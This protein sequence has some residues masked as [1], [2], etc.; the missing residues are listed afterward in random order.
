MCQAWQ[1]S[2]PNIHSRLR[3]LGLIPMPDP[4]LG[5]ARPRRRGLATIWKQQKTPLHVVLFLLKSK[6]NFVFELF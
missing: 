4:R 3:H 5:V 6:D 1:P 2:Q